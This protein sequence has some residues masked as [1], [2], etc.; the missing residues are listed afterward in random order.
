MNKKDMSRTSI[1]YF[2]SFIGIVFFPL[3]VN[4]QILNLYP[5]IGCRI[6]F[7]KEEVDFSE[8]RR[9]CYWDRI[10]TGC[11]WYCGFRESRI[12]ASSTLPTYK[13]IR[14]TPSNLEDFNHRTAWVEGVPGYGIGQR[15][16]YSLHPMTPRITDVF[17]V[18][19]YV[20]SEKS[21]RDNARVKTLRMYVN[22][23]PFAILHLKDIKNEQGFEFRP[24]AHKEKL[25]RPNADLENYPWWSITF[26]ILEVYPGEKF[27]DTAISEIYFT[28]LDVH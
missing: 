9:N 21:W 1:A 10:R 19:G 17:I 6:E 26:E 7:A 5:R 27:Q 12:S 22:H 15:I 13:G 16:T 20:K 8:V 23:T 25:R 18:N 3:L 11:S 28:G 4:S 2:I 24:I 14:Y